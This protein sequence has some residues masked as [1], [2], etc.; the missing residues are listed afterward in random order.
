MNSVILPIKLN[1]LE[2][3]KQLVTIVHNTAEYLRKLKNTERMNGFMV[4]VKS[5]YLEDY[6]C[7]YNELSNVL[8]KYTLFHC[9]M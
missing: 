4:F 9:F 8:G 2:W 7:T 5:V 6:I 3:Y 1:E